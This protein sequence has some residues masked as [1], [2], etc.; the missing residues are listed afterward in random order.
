MNS[1]TITGPEILSYTGCICIG[2]V[3]MFYGYQMAR[4]DFLVGLVPLA[5]ST[6]LVVFGG[7]SFRAEHVPSPENT[8]HDGDATRS[9][10]IAPIIMAALVA[11]L[12]LINIVGFMLDTAALILV[13][14]TTSGVRKINTIVITLVAVL[15][16]AFL[17]QQI[18]GIEL[19]RGML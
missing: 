18:L 11:F 13:V 6:L 4:D 15:G 3:G 19:P 5:T 9:L 16:I 10:W 17:F 8:V 1:R 7:L 2:L 12:F 14:M